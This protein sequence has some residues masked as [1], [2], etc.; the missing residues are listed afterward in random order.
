MAKKVLMV[1]LQKGVCYNCPI[2]NN[3]LWEE[4]IKNPRKESDG[5]VLSE[6]PETRIP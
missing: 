5:R 4:V 2:I 3:I 1:A 6:Y